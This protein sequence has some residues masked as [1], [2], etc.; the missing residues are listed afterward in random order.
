M[1]KKILSG[2]L[3]LNLILICGCGNKETDEQIIVESDNEQI[4]YTFSTVTRDDVELTQKID[5][6]YVQ[7]RDQEVSFNSTGKYVDKVYVHEGDTVKK[8]DLLCEL[9]YDSLQSDIE[10]LELNIN[11][12]QLKLTNLDERESIDEQ[13]AWLT[14]IYDWGNSSEAQESTKETVANIKA[15]YDKQRETLNDS[16]EFDRKELAQKKADLSSSRLYATLDGTVYDLKDDLVGSTSKEGE[17][18]MKIVDETDCL[19]ETDAIEYS[20]YFEEGE[21]YTMNVTYGT[22]SGSYDVTP[23]NISS[24]T[25]K[26]LFSVVS[27]PENAVMDVGTAG[28]IKIVTDSRENVLTLP[29]SS[30]RNSDE[31][32]YVYIANEENMKEVKWIEVGLMGD[33]NVEILSGLD[34]GDKVVL[35]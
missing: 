7:T 20:S 3:V 12:N 26:M 35:K 11:K 34:E 31:G 6:K 15:N 19:F 22:A 24:W 21:L 13:N 33:T 23:Y 28:N 8:G 30:V 32:Y 16:L 25:D 17:V 10:R 14:C 4:T 9:S 18:I 29:R 1:S 27:M 2:L 5:C